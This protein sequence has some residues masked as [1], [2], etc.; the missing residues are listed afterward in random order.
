MAGFLGITLGVTVVAVTGIA[1]VIADRLTGGKGIA[2]IAA[3]TTAG[4][5]AAVPAVIS[6]IDHFYERIAP[7]ATM[8]L[9]FRTRPIGE[10]IA[11]GMDTAVE[12]LL[13]PDVPMLGR[14]WG[15]WDHRFWFP[16]HEPL[17][18]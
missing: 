10:P 2:V 7:T 11:L 9:L 14:G 6:S 13:L 17:S 12:H 8:P 1:L 4:N 16:G 15:D 3:A 5:A 18:S